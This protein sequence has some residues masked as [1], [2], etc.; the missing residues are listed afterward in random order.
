MNNTQL[1]CI[2][3][4]LYFLYFDPYDP[5]IAILIDDFLRKKIVKVEKKYFWRL[6]N[7]L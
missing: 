7:K 1:K 2:K 5:I 3:I 6:L 4:V